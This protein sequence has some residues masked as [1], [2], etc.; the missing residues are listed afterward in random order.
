MSKSKK[1]IFGSDVAKENVKDLCHSKNRAKDRD[2]L[3]KFLKGELSEEELLFID[4]EDI[5]EELPEDD[6]DLDEE[7][8]NNMD[9]VVRY[10]N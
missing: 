2:I 10:D 6:F 5:E 3:N 1:R 4:D 7:S 9:S 8:F